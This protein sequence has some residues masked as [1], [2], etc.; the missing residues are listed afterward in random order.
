MAALWV[1]IEEVPHALTRWMRLALDSGKCL[2]DGAVRH[3]FMLLFTR[4]RERG[5][6]QTMHGLD[7]YCAYF[8]DVNASDGRLAA[9]GRGRSS[10]L[11][12][13][14]LV[15]RKIAVRKL[16]GDKGM[17]VG[18]VERHD[19]GHIAAYT[20]A[21]EDSGEEERRDLDSDSVEWSLAEDDSGAPPLHF[22]RVDAEWRQLAGFDPL[23]DAVLTAVDDEVAKK[24]SQFLMSLFLVAGGGEE[25]STARLL[26]DVWRELDESARASVD[27]WGEERGGSAMADVRKRARSLSLEMT[28][29][30]D[31]ASRSPEPCAGSRVA[32]SP[33]PSGDLSLLSLEAIANAMEVDGGERLRFLRLG[34][35]AGLLLLVLQQQSSV[36]GAH[37]RGRRKTAEQDAGDAPVAPPGGVK[38]EGAMEED[39]EVGTRREVSEALKLTP[40]S[41]WEGSLPPP[42]DA[43]MPC[44]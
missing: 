32:R 1:A 39:D 5:M 27:G 38:E 34:R 26:E 2:D 40:D 44:C 15:G 17:R 16:F 20:V 3:V 33:F 25:G 36:D 28:D 35:S 21:W 37:C 14:A 42:L 31:D 23:W 43:V 22:T 10:G 11:T 13:Q 19:K 7:C 24:G 29:A 8:A 9:A 12:G 41:R 6:L 4:G 30:H 18:V